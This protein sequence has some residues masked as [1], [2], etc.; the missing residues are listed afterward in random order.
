M[1]EL[2]DGLSFTADIISSVSVGIHSLFEVACK[3]QC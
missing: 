2:T 3:H 1:T